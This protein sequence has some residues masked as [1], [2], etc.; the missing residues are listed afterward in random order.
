MVKEPTIAFS[1]ADYD[2]LI[3]SIRDL[4]NDLGAYDQRAAGTPFAPDGNWLL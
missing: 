3:A 4:I 2:A 1:A